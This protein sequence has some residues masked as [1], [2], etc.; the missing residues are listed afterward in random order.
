M[1][2]NHFKATAKVL[3][4]FDFYEERENSY[5]QKEAVGVAGLIT[6]WNFPTN[7]VATKLAGAMAAGRT[8]VLKPAGMTPFAAIIISEVL[9]K[10][11]VPKSVFNLVNGTG[12]T[13]GDA[14]SSHPD[15][16]L[17]SST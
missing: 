3:R 16:Y 15:I 17:V 9:E 12:S 4:K 11:D 14:I 7:Q 1:G 8:F 6:P 5:I 2:L 13:L 10:A